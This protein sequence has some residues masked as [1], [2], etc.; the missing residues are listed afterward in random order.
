M[1]RAQEHVCWICGRAIALETCKID[2]VGYPIHEECYVARVALDSEST[3]LSNAPSTTDLSTLR[4]SLITAKR[5]G[6]FHFMPH[7]TTVS[8][9]SARTDTTRKSKFAVSKY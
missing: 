7:G 6:G 2:E 9:G 4:R 1:S 8:A 5:N 3:R